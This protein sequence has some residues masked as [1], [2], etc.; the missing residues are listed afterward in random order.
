[1]SVEVSVL[2]LTYNHERFIRRALES[3]VNQKTN[4]DFEIYIHDDA[5]T[6]GTQQ[7]LKEYESRYPNLVKLVIER[8]NQFSKGLAVSSLMTDYLNGRYI[9]ICEGDD[10]WIID[11]KLQEQYDAMEAHP[12][13]DICATGAYLQSEDNSLQED[14]LSTEEKVFSIEDVISGGAGFAQTCTLMYRRK[15]LVDKPIFR[16]GYDVDYLLQI[17]GAFRG[18][19]L[20]LPMLSGVYTSYRHPDS[21]GDYVLRSEQ[22]YRERI[23][24]LLD[25][26]REFD[27]YSNREYH[28]LIIKAMLNYKIQYANLYDK[29]DE[30]YRDKAFCRELG[31]KK[32]VYIYLQAKHPSICVWILKIQDK[33]LR[34]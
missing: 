28:G 7:I 2:C 32:R 22:N 15:I 24:P 9:A 1:M 29:W 14:T 33:I 11:T 27:D 8:E 21:Y 13:I 26:L 16:Q 12:E 30:L 23:F 3:F 34:R 6:D 4:F 20:Y 19:L 10:Y 25:K 18:G 31:L 5:S 17:D